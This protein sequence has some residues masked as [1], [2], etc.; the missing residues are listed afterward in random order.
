M[1]ELSGVEARMIAAWERLLAT[2]KGRP[3]PALVVV[4]GLG[5]GE[6]LSALDRH[7]PATRVLALE[8]N[9]SR[10]R[11]F[12]ARSEWRGWLETGRL[13]HLAGP[14][15]HGAAEASRTFPDNVDDHVVVVDP[16]I[17][18]AAGAEAVQAARILKTIVFGARANAEARRQ[19][20]PRYLANSLENASAI[21]RGRDV[22]AL[23]NAY[24]GVPAVIAAAGPSLDRAI[25]EWDR[26]DGR[27]LVIAADTALRP[28]LNAG[29]APHLVVGLDPSELNGRHFR[30]LPA[31]P[32]TSLVSESALDPA[33]SRHFNDRTF[34]F[35]VANHEPWPWYAEMGLDVALVE[36]WGSVIT[37][38][39]QVALLAG[40][41]PI[42]F[43][44]AD[45]S[46]TDGRPY[47]RGTTYEFDWAVGA[48]EGVDLDTIWR[49]STAQGELVTAPD[50]RGAPSVSTAALTAFRDWL[51]A[52]AARSGRRVINAT[53]AGMFFGPGIEQMSLGDALPNRRDVE[54]VSTAA[55]VRSE[56][57]R[58]ND[59]AAQFRNMRSALTS[60]TP[61]PVVD[62]WTAFC[63]GALDV[64]ATVAALGDGAAAL[65]DARAATASAPASGIVV[66]RLPEAILRWRSVL[67][68][69]DSVSDARS[70]SADVDASI[71]LLVEALSVLQRIGDAVRRE[72]EDLTPLSGGGDRPACASYAWPDEIGWDVT[73]FEAMLGH[74]SNLR[75]VRSTESFFTRPVDPREPLPALDGSGPQT[76]DHPNAARACAWL[77]LQWAATVLARDPADNADR[78][79]L[80]ALVGAALTSVQPSTMHDH[81][82]A[83]ATITLTTGVADGTRSIELPFEMS[84]GDLARLETGV[85]CRAT[86]TLDHRA[87][88][89]WE[90]TLAQLASNGRSAAVVLRRGHRPEAGRSHARV[91][92]RVLT[93][94]GVPRAYIAYAN[95]SEA[96]CV[97]PFS[98]S[99]F[100]VC[101]DG[102]TSAGREWPR[103]ILGELPIGSF[104]IA[105]WSNGLGGGAAKGSPYV[106]LRRADGSI[107]II[108]DL[109]F[110]PGR[111]AWCRDRLYW[112]CS[113]WGIGSWAPEGG[114][115]HALQEHSFIQVDVR[116]DELLLSPCVRSAAG[117]RLRRR[118]ERAWRWDGER[119]PQP[120]ELD[121]LGAETSRVRDVHGWTAT[122][123]PEA[124]LVTLES[125]EGAVSH[126]TCY[127]PYQLAWLEGSLLVGTSA[128]ELLLFEH[129]IDRLAEEGC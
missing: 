93:D 83:D 46:Y 33:A 82:S 96:I 34:W 113:L 70:I 44:G 125:P 88:P 18:A 111:G 127:F 5:R 31:C 47:C 2:L 30:G 59:L 109:P 74:A 36:V 100:S 49:A 7:A 32:D 9:P 54:R 38:A 39:F 19:L 67:R 108:D 123:F 78:R 13:I 89:R 72:P 26:V 121:S 87:E 41:D 81:G 119:D 53:G 55:A 62:R 124:D 80:R 128:G 25:A 12:L 118:P 37:A 99:S 35:R 76:L 95:R 58:P 122:A 45:L 94:E 65:D 120:I 43:V 110:R 73:E 69:E 86:R 101:A 1:D 92:P 115:A 29:R 16:A 22:A 61:N 11:A 105:A 51:V 56:A 75:Q 126:L 114:A 60:R 63:G 104:G 48:A 117:A 6:L 98:N 66:G 23:T 3:V 129:L 17:A 71:D 85:I 14:D 102:S 97:A 4:I 64:V 10:A 50:L 20:A 40:C 57:I 68:G 15:Y 103:P 52:H 24:R 90:E 77:A 79:R 42:V 27:G 107:E 28:L 91:M 84:S 21:L 106:M 116:D 8:P 112:T